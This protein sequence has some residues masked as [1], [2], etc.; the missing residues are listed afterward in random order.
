MG[1]MFTWFSVYR[2]E[3]SSSSVGPSFSWLINREARKAS[4]ASVEKSIAAGK[5]LAMC[6]LRRASCLEAE[7]SFPT[8]Q[9]SELERY[10]RE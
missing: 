4:V 8:R 1:A 2:R 3:S 5:R 7:L 9:L 10:R 6:F